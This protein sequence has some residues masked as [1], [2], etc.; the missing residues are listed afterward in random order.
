MYVSLVIEPSYCGRLMRKKF[1]VRFAVC[2]AG[3]LRETDLK[4]AVVA[5]NGPGEDDVF[6]PCAGADVVNDE[7]P[8][9]GF[10][11]HIRDDAD[12]IDAVT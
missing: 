12:V 11:N 10:G 4:E 5:F 9:V 1:N 2:E 3:L 6:D 8:I 7:E